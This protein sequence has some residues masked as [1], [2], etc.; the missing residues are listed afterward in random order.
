M[1]TKCKSRDVG[2]AR[3]PFTVAGPRLIYYDAIHPHGT[4]KPESHHHHTIKRGG[5][6][7]IASQ[8]HFSDLL[9]VA[10]AP[11]EKQEQILDFLSQVQ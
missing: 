11:E 7:Q 9:K 10:I 3:S 5:G 8:I 4:S 6:N 1:F 2:G